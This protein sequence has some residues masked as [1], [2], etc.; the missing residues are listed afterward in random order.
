MIFQPRAIASIAATAEPGW[1]FPLGE[2][3]D[4]RALVLGRVQP[5]D[6]GAPFAGVDRPGRAEES[7][8]GARSAQALKIAIEPWREPDVRMQRDRHR[9]LRD[10]RVAMGDGDRVLLMQAEQHLGTL[11]AE[12]VDEAVVKSRGSP[13]ARRERESRKCRGGASISAGTS[14]PQPTVSSTG[15]STGSA[16]QFSPVALA[17]SIAEPPLSALKSCAN[18]RRRGGSSAVKICRRPPRYPFI[19]VL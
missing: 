2:M 3:P 1:S 11:V 14:E 15:P 4:Q 12:V 16:F 5:V 8:F 6:P 18:I 17:S 9:T 19:D 10:L 7:A 13:R